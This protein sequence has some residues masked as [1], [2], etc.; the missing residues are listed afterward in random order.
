MKD[1]VKPSLFFGGLLLC[2]GL[3]FAQSSGQKVPV[4][5]IPPGNPA[6]ART[7]YVGASSMPAHV[8]H[9]DF[10]G[11]CWAGQVAGK[12]ESF[13]Q[14]LQNN[15]SHVPQNRSDSSKALGSPDCLNSEGG[16][17]SL[18]FGGSII[19]KMDG[20]I[21]NIPGNDLR[22]C[23]TTFGNLSC[24]QFPEYARIFVS[25]DNL[26]WSDLGTICQDGEV[27]I[28]PLRWILYVKIVDETDPADFGSQLADGFDLDGVQRILPAARMA[29]S[30]TYLQEGEFFKPNPVAEA[31]HLDLSAAENNGVIHIRIF[32]MKGSIF[33]KTELLFDSKE[34]EINLDCKGL[35]PGQYV[36]Q[37]EG[38]GLSEI[39]RIVKE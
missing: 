10:S 23:E 6:E 9:G 24:A 1:S 2:T 12:V 35:P 34:P 38:A 15:G 20:G 26:T 18:G 36:L 13:Q 19:L 7:I 22:I 25:Q 17:V 29:V 28:A 21:L 39:R 3:S 31:L 16:F 5:H 8:A 11:D 30:G 4:C 14:G 27:D 37:V 33:Q 32:D